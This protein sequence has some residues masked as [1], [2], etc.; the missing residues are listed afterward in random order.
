MRLAVVGR[1]AEHDLVPTLLAA[2]VRGSDQKMQVLAFTVEQEEFAECVAHLS[3]A[4]FRGIFVGNPH[5]PMAAKLASRFFVV[6]H[7]LGVANALMLGP[8]IYAQNTEVP[9]FVQCISGVEPGTALV[10]GSGRAARSVVM[11]LFELGWQVKLW[12]RNALRSRPFLTLFARYG[13][14]EMSPQADPSGCKL[15][16]NATP[17]GAKAGEMPPVQWTRARPHTVAVDL[18]FRKVATEF[19]REAANRGFRTVDGRELLVE[20]AALCLEWWTGKAASR[21]AMRE[22][23]DLPSQ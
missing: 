17:L 11:G 13:N 8:E 16:V 5:K 20:Q 12:N 15:V 18:V 10:M 23:A 19:L 21:A 4:G 3:G 7:A 22:A 14:I 1:G 6:K 2:G 9:A